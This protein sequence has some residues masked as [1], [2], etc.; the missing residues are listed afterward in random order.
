[1]GR[2]L[3]AGD[4][5]SEFIL[6]REIGSGGFA[7]VWRAVHKHLPG[8]V[9]AIKIP[10]NAEFVRQLAGEGRIQHRLDHPRI[11]RTLGL[12]LDADPPYFVM[13][14][15]DGG[16][17]RARLRRDGR[18]P[19]DEAL[20][21]FRHVLEALECAHGQGV[22]HLDVK[23]ENILL[24]TGGDAKLSD[25]GLGRAVHATTES[26]LVSGSLESRRDVAGTL[27]Y[28]P[29]EQREGRNVD[30]RADLYAAGIVLFEMLTGERPEHG[31]VP[32][33]LVPGLDARIDD[34]FGRCCARPDQ[35]FSSARAVLDALA[36][37][38]GSGIGTPRTASPFA[39][40]VLCGRRGPRDQ[41]FCAFCGAESPVLDCPA[42]GKPVARTDA[43][44]VSCGKPLSG[45]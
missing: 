13:E 32:S 2:T 22:L 16:S 23:P 31:D 39:H 42:C 38:A 36:A 24:D 33:R 28:M 21:I 27:A 10:D 9:V 37:P 41:R 45:S 6:D 17:L 29:R 11:V 25:F 1:M 20:R 35:R 30:A 34:I 14:L 12:D 40:C 15:V 19:C 44:C 4:A 5:I 3:K 7:R 26:I 18:L 8:R 43:F